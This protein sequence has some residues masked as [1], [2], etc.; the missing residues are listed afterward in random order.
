MNELFNLSDEQIAE[1]TRSENKELYAELVSRYE[2]KL[3][4]Y[5]MYLI[6]DRQ[7]AIDAVQ[8]T[9]IKAFIN[10]NSFNTKKKFSSW[11]Y[12]IAH[13]EAINIA[14]KHKREMPLPELFE[15]KSNEDIIEEITKE[16]IMDKANACLGKMPIKYAEPLILYY[17]DDKSYDEI[18]DIMQIPAGTVA[19]RINR[20]KV[21]MK[22]LC[23]TN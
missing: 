15:P 21:I 13:N 23:Q 19:T 11:I 8:E 14:K 3:F 4:Y 18:S 7:K 1:K 12:R 6:E 16:E 2:E 22:K 9:F 20:A 17:M 10:L 5:V